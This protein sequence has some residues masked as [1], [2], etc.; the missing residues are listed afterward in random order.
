MK[1]EVEKMLADH[2]IRPSTSP[3]A[4]PIVLVQKKDGGVRFCVDFCK[5]NQVTK[6]DAYT[7]LQ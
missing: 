6:F 2:V 4:T 5:L 3:W 7:M 1:E